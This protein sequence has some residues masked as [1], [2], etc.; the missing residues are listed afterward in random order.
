M[1]ITFF[2]VGNVALLRR[3]EEALQVRHRKLY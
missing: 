3:L 2:F 1:A